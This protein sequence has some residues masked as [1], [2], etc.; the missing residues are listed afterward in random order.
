MMKPTQLIRLLLLVVVTTFINI[1][2]VHPQSHSSSAP[3]RD[4]SKV[5]SPLR[6]TLGATNVSAEE[7]VLEVG[8]RPYGSQ[9]ETELT[10]LNI[11]VDPIQ[12]DVFNMSTNVSAQWISA[13]H[14]GAS[15]VTIPPGASHR[16]RISF[17]SVANGEHVPSIMFMEHWKQI[18]EVDVLYTP[19]PFTAPWEMPFRTAISAVGEHPTIVYRFC[20]LHNPPGLEIKTATPVLVAAKGEDY[21]PRGCGDVWAWCPV[22]PA[23]PPGETLC[24]DAI[25]Q[26]HHEGNAT[27]KDRAVRFDF[28]IKVEYQPV[29]PIFSLKVRSDLLGP[30]GFSPVTR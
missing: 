1:E 5:I 8:L 11:S 10:I 20:L 23:R 3:E 28:S 17:I 30:T 26:G 16:L 2:L 22:V 29:A 18:G 13:D 9:A 27:A 4:R 24:Y 14:E 25:V 19:V 7:A 6:I 12:V 21:D 15:R